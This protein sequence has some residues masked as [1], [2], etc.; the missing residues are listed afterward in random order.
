MKYRLTI[1]F[2]LLLS[3]ALALA[4]YCLPKPPLLQGIPFSTAVWDENG[5]LLRLSLS[6]DEKYRLY[7]PLS[8]ISPQLIE[9]TLLQ[10]DQYFYQHPGLNPVAMLKAG[11]Q[12]YVIRSR[13]QGASTIT[14]QLA[15]IR[16]NVNSKK[17]T[18]KLLQ[19]IRAIQ[20]ERHYSKQQIL[21]AYLNLAP[22]GGNIEGIGAASQIYFNHSANQLGLPEALTLSVI[23]QNPGKRTP[24]NQQLKGIRNK[25]FNRWLQIHPEDKRYENAMALPLAMKTIRDLPFAAPHFVNS[26]LASNGGQQ[27]IHTT[28]DLK[29]QSLVERITQRYLQRKKA[30][31][32]L[33]LQFY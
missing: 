19:M 5:H 14:M 15:R 20:L 23:P 13:R 11:W 17:W 21:E 12:T 16:F 9:A 6:R 25:L 31:V 1:I 26:L 10:E 3:A 4:Y 8:D 29:L 18:G 22:Y 33:M 27:Q 30:S 2:S 28:L 7:L 24:K 32:Y